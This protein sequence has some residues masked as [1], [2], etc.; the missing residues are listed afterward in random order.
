MIPAVACIEL[1]IKALRHNVRRVRE[2][3]PNSKLMAVIKASRPVLHQEYEL[4]RPLLKVVSTY[5]LA[6]I[7]PLLTALP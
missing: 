3:A 5:I 1:D 6:R 4:P 7:P 2:L